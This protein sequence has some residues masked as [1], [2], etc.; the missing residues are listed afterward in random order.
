M[1]RAVDAVYF[2]K[3]KVMLGLI[4]SF[5]LFCQSIAYVMQLILNCVV[6]VAL[7]L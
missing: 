5:S 7:V 6:L 4:S 1:G 3:D 2:R